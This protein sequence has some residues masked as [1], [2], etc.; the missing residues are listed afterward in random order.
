M[1]EPVI[2]PVPPAASAGTDATLVKAL[3]SGAAWAPIT[4]SALRASVRWKVTSAARDQAS[5]AL[6]ASASKIAR[7][8][9]L[10]PRRPSTGTMSAQFRA[11]L[12]DAA[13]STIA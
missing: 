5:K 6:A 1:T 3:P 8:I 10:L 2:L 9:R 13:L 11:P 4:M 7:S 12:K